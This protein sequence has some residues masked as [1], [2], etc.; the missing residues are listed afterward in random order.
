[1]TVVVAYRTGEV[2]QQYLLWKSFA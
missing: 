2:T 1:M